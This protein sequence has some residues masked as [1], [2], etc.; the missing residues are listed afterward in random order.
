M[1]N[2]SLDILVVETLLDTTTSIWQLFCIKS[3]DGL[4]LNTGETQYGYFIILS[5]PL[6]SP[7]TCLQKY[8]L[9]FNCC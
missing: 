1:F 9:S 5:W 7:L 4:I 2:N 8:F 6:K 3:S